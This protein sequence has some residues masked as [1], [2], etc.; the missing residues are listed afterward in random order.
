M[1]TLASSSISSCCGDEAE[2]GRAHQDA[3]ADERD[4][5]RLAQPGTEGPDGERDGEDDGD[6]E[7]RAVCHASADPRQELALGLGEQPAAEAGVEH[8]AAGGSATAV[9]MTA[10]SRPERM[11]RSAAS[12]ASPGPAARRAAPCPR[13]RPAGRCRAARRPPAPRRAPAA[14][15]RRA[16]MPTPL[17]PPSRAARS[18][19]R[20]GSGPSSRRRRRRRPRAPRDEAVERRHVRAQVAFERQAVARRHDRDAVVADRAGDEDPV[21]RAQPRSRAPRA[22]RRD[23]GR[24]EH[25]AVELAAPIT[26]VSPVTIAAPASRQAAGSRP[27]CARGRAREALLDDHRR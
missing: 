16:T 4:D 23:A 15:P 10:A 24:V 21:A 25:D 20:R 3:H 19:R 2:P 18:R 5:E 26:L 1:P 6:F 9:P 17:L 11:A 27:G 12:T 14:R 13:W 7:K 22:R 8:D